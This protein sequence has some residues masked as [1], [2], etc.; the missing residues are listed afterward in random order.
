[1]VMV[2]MSTT[3]VAVS[4]GSESSQGEKL[5]RKERKDNDESEEPRSWKF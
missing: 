4:D 5:I 2:V 1:M 3:R